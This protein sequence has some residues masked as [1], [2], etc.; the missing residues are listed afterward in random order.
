MQKLKKAYDIKKQLV[1]SDI[2]ELGNILKENSNIETI[3]VNSDN[4]IYLESNCGLDSIKDDL[5]EG[6]RKWLWVDEHIMRKIIF[7]TL[8]IG[9]NSCI[10]RV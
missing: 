1:T 6:I 8:P 5:D 4:T 10:I 3:D 9:N 2:N 7:N